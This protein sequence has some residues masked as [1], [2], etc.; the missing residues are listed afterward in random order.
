LCVDV[1]D[2]GSSIR[3]LG[4]PHLLVAVVAEAVVAAHRHAVGSRREWPWHVH[5]V[6][7]GGSGWLLGIR[8]VG[9]EVFGFA[10]VKRT[11]ELLLLLA[12]TWLVLFC[13][14]FMALWLL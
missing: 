8:A 1:V 12:V 14:G 5:R 4:L 10:V 3:L 2:A 9:D 11:R 7:V 6:G 13:G